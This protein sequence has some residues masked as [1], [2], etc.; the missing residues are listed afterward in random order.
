MTGDYDRVTPPGQEGSISVA[1]NTRKFK[2]PISKSVTITTNAPGMKRVVLTMKATV[3]SPLEIRPSDRADFRVYHGDGGIRLLGLVLRED[4]EAEVVSIQSNN[5]LIAVEW[6]PWSPS[7][8]S[9][10]EERTIFDGAA[11]R[12]YR[13]EIR[14]QPDAAVGYH[15]GRI[16]IH[17]DGTQQK[18]VEIK[19]LARV[20]GRIHFTPQWLYFGSV[21]AG[22]PQLSER[23]LEVRAHG[24]IPF[25][26]TGVEYEGCPIKWEIRP[27]ED[28]A[29]TDIHF[30]WEGSEPAGIH[31]GRL[32]VNTDY[33]AQPKLEV[34]FS[35]NVL[36]GDPAEPD[37]VGNR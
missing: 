13:L 16:T 29:G 15:S 23:L 22:E 32:V 36:A 19:A 1:L 11:G 9:S 12:A 8:E 14:L 2:K 33:P 24:E 30:R 4:T 26:V 34:P 35:I 7:E 3:R 27:L 31:K 28:C 6:G 25:T 18:Q 10:D 21:A 37:T 5:D 20:M 17:L